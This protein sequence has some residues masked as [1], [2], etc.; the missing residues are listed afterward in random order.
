MCNRLLYL[1]VLIKNLCGL[2]YNIYNYLTYSYMY[3]IM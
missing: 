1:E 3:E 2:V